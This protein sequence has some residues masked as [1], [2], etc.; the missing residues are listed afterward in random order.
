MLKNKYMRLVNDMAVFT[1]GTVL[2]KL[3]QFVLMPLYTTYMTTEAYGVA[4]LT[5]N[6]SELLFPIV[7]LCIY[8]AVFRYVIGS[9][10][11]KEEIVTSSIKVLFL[12]SLFGA[13][14]VFFL[15]FV[16][17]YKYAFYLYLILYA[18]SF[19]MLI[20]Y[21][22]RGKGYSKLFAISG[23]V[24][25]F[26]LALFSVLFLVYFRWDVKGYLLA[27]AFSY[28]FSMLFLLIGGGLYK[29]IRFNI[30]TNLITRELLRYSM[31]L[32]IYNVGYWIT[33]M[34][35]RYILLWNTDV[36][37]AG[38]YA[39][40]IKMA[41]VI[42]MLQQAFYAAFQLNTSREYESLDKE[43]YFSN[44]FRLYAASI[45]MFGSVILCFS[46]LLAKI[47]LKYEFYAAKEFLPLILFIAIID[48]L[49]CFLKTMYTTYKY[50]KR[51]VPSML[52]GSIVN[53]VVCL[54]TV[55][56]YGIWGI[57]IASLL[58]YI[59]QALYRVIDV[60]KFVN[61]RYD[62]KIIISGL[63]ALSIQVILLT[64]ENISGIV[65]ACFIAILVFVFNFI[66]YK[67]EIMQVVNKVVKNI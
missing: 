58:C 66:Y 11:S 9:K 30:K 31:P 62:W 19:R 15:H 40:V 49:F 51:A 7:T 33:T 37:T 39:A 44:I 20:A 21:Y 65:I 61:I 1:V 48:C 54:L 59:S 28:I 24:N 47:T 8:E 50:T 10:Y 29:E 25:A 55:N 34:S 26:F 64:K 42:N 60:K 53:V 23:I 3:V 36:S 67:K 46:P 17:H 63:A 13:I 52:I 43:N 32:I 38:V 16:L 57:C 45:V 35:G 6:M 12:S 27:I 56:K 22:A 14:L 5:N 4:E 41:S 18:Y 2:T